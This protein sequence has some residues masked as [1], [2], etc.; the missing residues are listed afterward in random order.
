MLMLQ[1][2]NWIIWKLASV[3]PIVIAAIL[4]TGCSTFA[5]Q[6]AATEDTAYMTPIPKETLQA[7]QWDTPVRNKMDAVI[8][9][10]LSL[11]TTR[12]SYMETPKVL[13]VEE[14][15]LADARKRVAQPGVFKTY[16][17]G[18]GDAKV[19]LV[20]FEGDWQMTGGPL[21][22]PDPEHPETPGPPSHGCVYVIIALDG[23]SHGEI[24]TTK[25]SP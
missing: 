15:S 4:L 10:R 12:L 19:W 25:C 5:G 3:V 6:G 17:E 18:S 8:L 21:P 1:E 2:I 24:G 20:L 7:Y 13:S 22:D 11:D 23:S 14:M 16:E 9:A